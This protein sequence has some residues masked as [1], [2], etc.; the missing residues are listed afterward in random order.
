MARTF[1]LLAYRTILRFLYKK[2]LEEIIKEK[3]N[4]KTY[5][6]FCKQ[7][8]DSPYIDQQKKIEMTISEL[9]KCQNL[10]IIFLQ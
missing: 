1:D 2:S 7:W 8:F 10:D 9:S 3:A 4:T 6:T 5:E